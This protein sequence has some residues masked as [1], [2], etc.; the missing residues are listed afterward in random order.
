MIRYYPKEEIWSNIIP[1]DDQESSIDKMMIK[2]P[3]IGKMMIKYHL[4]KVS[5]IKYRPINLKW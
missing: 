2:N 3:L 1:T 4:I 5:S